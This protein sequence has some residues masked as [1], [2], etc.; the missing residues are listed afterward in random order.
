MRKPFHMQPWNSSLELEKKLFKALHFLYTYA[1]ILDLYPFTLDDFAK[2]FHDKTET[3]D[4]VV[5][6]WKTSLNPLTWTE[7]LRQVLIAAGFGSRDGNQSKGCLTKITCPSMDF[8]N[9]ST[10]N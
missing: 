2:A 4:S 5:N 7:I 1:V 3:Q 9:Y 10:R 6:F 8:M